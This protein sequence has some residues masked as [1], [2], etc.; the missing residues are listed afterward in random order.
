MTFYAIACELQGRAFRDTSAI[1]ETVER[2][3]GIRLS[4]SEAEQVR[5]LLHWH[6][7]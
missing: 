1:V 7:L 3:L 2:L 6:A 5:T 4:E